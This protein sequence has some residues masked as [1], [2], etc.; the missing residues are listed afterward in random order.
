LEGI[1]EGILGPG[2]RGL[3][4][5]GAGLYSTAIFAGLG[6]AANLTCL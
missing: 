5:I 4:E 1:L 6:G 3:A 2:S